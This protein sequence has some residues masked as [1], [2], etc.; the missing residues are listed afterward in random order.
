MNSRTL[1]PKRPPQSD[2]TTDPCAVSTTQLHRNEALI[3]R[4]YC[5]FSRRDAATMAA[6]YAPDAVFRDPAF[7]LRGERIGQMWSM[8]TSQAGPDFKI[9]FENVQADEQR[10]RAHWE[11]DYTFSISGRPVHNIIEARFTFENG[12]I[13]T[14]VD[15]F[16]FW[17]WS[18]Q[19]L[20]L[21]GLLLGWTPILRNKVREQAAKRL[22][23]FAARK[24][25]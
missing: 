1:D 6:C 5:A 2:K 10:G 17:R 8:L 20:G 13:K 25:A 16:N 15:D 23:R 3:K 7:E 18:Q 12:L 19:A 4:F 9:E 11:A 14:H 22:E 24:P 21:P